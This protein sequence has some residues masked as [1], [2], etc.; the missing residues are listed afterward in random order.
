MNP[1]KRKKLKRIRNDEVLLL[2]DPSRSKVNF[3]V[4]CHREQLFFEII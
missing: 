3:S 2:G 4:Y 1:G